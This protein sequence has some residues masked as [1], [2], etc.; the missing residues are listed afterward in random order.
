M[1]EWTKIII[2]LY[3][4]CLFHVAFNEYSDFYKLSVVINISERVS[5]QQDNSDLLM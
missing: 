2:V 4:T 5:S 1:D 3:Y